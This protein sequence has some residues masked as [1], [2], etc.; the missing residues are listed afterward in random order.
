[1][2]INITENNLQVNQ[3]KKGRFIIIF[4]ALVFFGLLTWYLV[5][6]SIIVAEYAEKLNSLNDSIFKARVGQNFAPPIQTDFLENLYNLEEKRAFQ[7]AREIMSR[8]DSVR[9]TIHL[10][11]STLRIEIKGLVVHTAKILHFKKSGVLN[12]LPVMAKSGWL[13]EPFKA[14]KSISTIVREPIVVKQA[15][16]DTIEAQNMPET[17]PQPETGNVYFTWETGRNLIIHIN[18][19]EEGKMKGF[20]V[21]RFKRNFR[22][23]R[24]NAV[25]MLNFR[26][27]EYEHT[28]ELTLDKRDARIVY[29]ALPE[30]PL[31]TVRL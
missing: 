14:E 4:T 17:V 10:P 1:M 8:T 2:E 20:L 30:F 25:A 26:K 28:L 15:P 11:D 5:Y 7:N 22:I 9:L 16:A 29:R 31:I 24:K 27:T 23:F 18:Q 19:V 12:N 3:N 21:Q 13:S 6:R